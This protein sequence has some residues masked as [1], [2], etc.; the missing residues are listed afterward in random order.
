MGSPAVAPRTSLI[1]IIVAFFLA[2]AA[3]A[4]LDAAS[5][6][7]TMVFAFALA[8]CIA[9]ALTPFAMYL[10]YR[11]G[12][13]D[14]PD[15]R[16][17]H[18]RPTPLLG[19]PAVLAAF[20]MAT[21]AAIAALPGSALSP[22]LRSQLLATLGAGA[23]IAALGVADDKWGLST[24]VR[25]I[26]QLAAVLLVMKFGVVMTFLPPTGIGKAGEI[27]LTVIWIVGITNAL[28]FLDGLDGLASGVAMMAA[29]SF[30]A[31]ALMTD[32]LAVATA[33]FCLAGA[34]A[35]FLKY[36]FRPASVYLGDSGA[37]F[38]GF[39]LACI[40]IIG[41]WGTP[42]HPGRI[43]NLLVPVIILAIPIYDTIYITLYRIKAGHV[44]TLREWAAYVGRD[45]L[46]HRLQHLGM[47]PA[48]AC[49]FIWLGGLVLGILAVIVKTKGDLDRY[50]K[51]LALLVAAMMCVGATILMELGKNGMKTGEPPA[52]ANSR[53]GTE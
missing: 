36:N 45:H 10:S 40:G 29:L 43:E 25:L 12:L 7:R 15:E 21:A 8:A 5:P 51:F 1:L 26:V 37:T 23:L 30:G 35:G 19:G 20:A 46:H 24:G 42:A 39:T 44:R 28:N 41:D 4:G 34:T 14:I 47:R 17:D 33:S 32:Q 31:I 38:L 48:R 18:D 13:L 2:V 9:L 49:L 52:G 50:D 11:T 3:Y 27:I 22:E 16:K 53:R 6:D